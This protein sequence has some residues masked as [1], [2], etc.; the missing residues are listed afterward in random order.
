EQD[1]GSED[2]V[3]PGV[4]PS[5]FKGKRRDDK[6]QP[7]GAIDPKVQPVGNDADEPGGMVG[8][9]GQE[10]RGDTDNNR[11]PHCDRFALAELQHE[12]R[13]DQDDREGMHERT[14]V[15]VPPDAFDLWLDCGK[16]DALTAAGA[17]FV[18]P[19]EGLL[20]AYEIS[21]AVNHTA[22]DGPNLI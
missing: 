8:Q 3:V 14:P 1:T 12:R 9:G 18:P 20:E 2:P 10:Q 16:V 21:P 22:N 11:K 4:E 5:E 6:H 7:D 17:L 13:C 19:P 15:I